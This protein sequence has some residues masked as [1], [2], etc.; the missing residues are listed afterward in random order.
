MSRVLHRTA[1]AA[2]VAGAGVVALGLAASA[3]GLR[4]NMTA[5]IPP[6]L[7]RVTGEP[8]VAGAF[9]LVCP[10]RQPV[11]EVAL[12]RGYLAPGNCPGGYG[13]LMKKVWAAERDRVDLADSGVRVNGH[14]VPAS[15][16]M[17]H[18]GAGRPMPRPQ[19]ASATLDA[20]HVL[21]MSDA[22]P[23]SFDGRYFGLTS[24]SQI[25]AVIRPVFTWN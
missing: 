16:R 7:Y 1:I 13:Y 14:L 22:N 6:G 3:A 18:D 24:R 8:A 20:G 23:R 25:V 9:V 2:A 19:V 5:S 17:S 21:L 10:P 12:K 15:A 11:F 4:V